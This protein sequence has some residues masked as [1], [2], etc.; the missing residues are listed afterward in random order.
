MA[1]TKI[2]YTQPTRNPTA[3]PYKLSTEPYAALFNPPCSAYPV[4]NGG[5]IDVVMLIPGGRFVYDGDPSEDADWTHE[6]ER[7]LV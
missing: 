3:T 6:E 5:E 4:I 1:R 2:I 7:E